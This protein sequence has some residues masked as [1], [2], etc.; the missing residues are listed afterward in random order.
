MKVV[1]FFLLYFFLQIFY[2]FFYIKPRQ[3]Q[4]DQKIE[5]H[6]KPEI[7]YVQHAYARCCLYGRSANVTAETQKPACKC[8]SDTSAK[9]CAQRCAGVNSKPMIIGILIAHEK[10]P[11]RLAFFRT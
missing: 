6:R 9:L 11:N 10:T 2:C 4:S 1:L 7:H 5:D 3:D 8:C